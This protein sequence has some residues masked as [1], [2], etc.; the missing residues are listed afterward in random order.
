[1]TAVQLVSVTLDD[2]GCPQD[3]IDTVATFPTY[4][5]AIAAMRFLLN[6]MDDPRDLELLSVETGR[7]LSWVL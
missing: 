6:D 2:E 1:V 5:E 3:V 4:E 7:W